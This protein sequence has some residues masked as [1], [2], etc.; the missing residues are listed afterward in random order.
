MYQTTHRRKEYA[1]PQVKVVRFMVEQGFAGSNYNN[2]VVV[3]PSTN[4][5]SPGMENVGMNGSSLDGFFPR[6]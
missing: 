3:N 5:S 1:A 2:V 4:E 6:S